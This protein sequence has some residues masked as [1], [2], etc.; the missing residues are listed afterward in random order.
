MNVVNTFVKIALICIRR[1]GYLRMNPPELNRHPKNF[2]D[3]LQDIY[4][5]EI[6]DYYDVT[7]PN[8]LS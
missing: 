2:L 8:P 4:T 6:L 3:T 1:R 7:L 5:V